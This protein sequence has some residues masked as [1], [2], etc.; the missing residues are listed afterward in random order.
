MG[1]RENIVLRS[2]NNGKVDKEVGFAK[3][4]IISKEGLS[5]EVAKMLEHARSFIKANN[6]QG[7]V[8]VIEGSVEEID[9]P[10][11]LM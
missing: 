3:T 2:S 7:I 5:V 4:S 9:L 6:L 10:K 8:E 1:S 11:K